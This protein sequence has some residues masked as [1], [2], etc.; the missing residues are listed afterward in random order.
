MQRRSRI[1]QAGRSGAEGNFG[2]IVW[3][4]LFGLSAA[5]KL[6]PEVIGACAARAQIKREKVFCQV[7]RII[8]HFHTPPHV[9]ERST[10]STRLA[11]R[12]GSWDS[13]KEPRVTDVHRKTKR[14]EARTPRPAA[15]TPRRQPQPESAC[16]WIKRRSEGAGSSTPPPLISRLRCRWLRRPGHARRM[17]GHVCGAELRGSDRTREPPQHGKESAGSRHPRDRSPRAFPALG[18]AMRSGGGSVV[19]RSTPVGANGGERFLLPEAGTRLELLQFSR[20][21]RVP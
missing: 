21:S 2:K 16:P 17:F 14:S 6:T 12:A 4:H 11:N 18:K 5:T 7:R 15:S 3:E 20:T 1:H 19:L 9:A 8:T 13:R 10:R